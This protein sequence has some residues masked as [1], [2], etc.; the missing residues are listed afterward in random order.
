MDDNP[1]N[2][3]IRAFARANRLSAKA[4]G[5]A[6]GAGNAYFSRKVVGAYSAD[7]IAKLFIVFPNLSPD[8]VL[9][10]LGEMYRHIETVLDID[11][12]TI[13][14]QKVDD[15]ENFAKIDAAAESADYNYQHSDYVSKLLDLLKTKDE[16]ISL[17]LEMLNGK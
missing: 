6:V 2:E 3:R 12:N 7:Y 4:L 16:Q 1:I 11:D 13:K 10:G 15:A 14:D 17:L 8:W 5:E 9:N